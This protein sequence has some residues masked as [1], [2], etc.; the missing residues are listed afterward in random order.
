MKVLECTSQSPDLNLIGVL[1]LNRPFML[2]NPPNVAELKQF[3][4]EDWAKIS[5]QR[6]ERLIAS[7]HKDLIAV[8]AAMGGTTSY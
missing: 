4:K 5:P 6:C 7:Y 2:K 1:S 3:C 8:P